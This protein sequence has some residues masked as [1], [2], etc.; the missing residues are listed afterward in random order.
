[1]TKFDNLLSE[2]N[3]NMATPVNNTKTSRNKQFIKK[4]P[5]RINPA[6]KRLIVDFDKTSTYEHF[7]TVVKS[8]I[9]ADKEKRIVFSIF[10]TSG[11]S[12]QDD[13][14]VLHPDITSSTPV[15]EGRC[16][17]F[18]KYWRVSEDEIYSEEYT[19]PTWKD[20]INACNNLLQNG[21]GFGVFLENLEF[22]RKVDGVNYFKFLIGS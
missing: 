16:V 9:D 1:M 17:F 10:E 15:I 8:L 12:I 11:D 18:I 4:P 5:G 2:I 21:D 20:I 7:Q 3:N 13:W 19:N 22:S 6:T 14:T